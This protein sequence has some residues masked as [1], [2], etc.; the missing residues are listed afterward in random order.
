MI[1]DLDNQ[2]KVSFF[3]SEVMGC[4]KIS[5]DRESS[6]EIVNEIGEM[7]KV[8]FFERN[9]EILN[10]NRPFINQIKRCDDI[11]NKLL[12]I[13]YEMKKMGKLIIRCEEPAEFIS[14]YR[15]FITN[16][17]KAPQTHIDE[18]EI[19]TDINHDKLMSNIKTLSDLNL[20]TRSLLDYKRVL[21]KT[22]NIVNMKE[23]R[24]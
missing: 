2:K 5:I 11:F 19:E 14:Y 20:K 12:Q 13:E 4:Y 16:R 8:H 9:P 7:G 24:E 18:I 6:W 22:R 23:Q 21:L 10:F 17:G 3:R 15:E 1:N